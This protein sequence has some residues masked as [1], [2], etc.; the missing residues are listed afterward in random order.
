M[1]P[2]FEGRP[3][4]REAVTLNEPLV[5]IHTEPS[6][7]ADQGPPPQ[8]GRRRLSD[9]QNQAED[10]LP[11]PKPQRRRLSTTVQTVAEESPPQPQRVSG[12]PRL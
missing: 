8:S 9:I 11:E 2:G 12:R 4:D 6:S 10:A 3:S 7:P 1:G 5:D